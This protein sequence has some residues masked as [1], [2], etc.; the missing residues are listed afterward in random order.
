MLRSLTR[1]PIKYK[2]SELFVSLFCS[3]KSTEN[4]KAD[5][6]LSQA[7]FKYNVRVM[8]EEKHPAQ[9]T[10]NQAKTRSEHY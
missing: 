9:S 10:C 8:G 5:P 3:C 6:A 2:S 4:E 7:T 1:K